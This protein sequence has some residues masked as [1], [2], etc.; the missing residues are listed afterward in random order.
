MLSVYRRGMEKFIE[1]PE[2]PTTL[3]DTI[4]LYFTELFDELYKAFMKAI[5]SR[6][7]K[8]H[9]SQEK[10]MLD[11]IPKAISKFIA[12]IEEI[13]AVELMKKE[14]MEEIIA[15]DIMESE[16]KDDV[17]TTVNFKTFINEIES[18]ILIVSENINFQKIKY[19]LQIKKENDLLE[20]VT[21]MVREQI[22]KI[23]KTLNNENAS[24]LDL[25]SVAKDIFELV[26]D[27]LNILNHFK[28]TTEI[29]EIKVKE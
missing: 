1:S 22:G 13:I 2:V 21:E 17:A 29:P 3:A 23:E 28:A 20:N 11:V 25:R 19:M 24:F 15:V 10:A 4:K 26:M 6:A 5:T 7:L 18:Y 16:G 8:Y 27:V 12:L 14:G 9:I